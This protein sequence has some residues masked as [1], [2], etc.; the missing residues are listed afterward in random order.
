MIFTGHL[1]I[2][3]IVESCSSVLCMRL[4]TGL[5]LYVKHISTL[6]ERKVRFRGYLELAK[7]ISF[8]IDNILAG[9]VNGIEERYCFSLPNPPPFPLP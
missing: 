4:A 1:V 7:H 6:N 3:S 9:G 5:K 8:L 2:R